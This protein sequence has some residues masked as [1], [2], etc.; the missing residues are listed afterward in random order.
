[1]ELKPDRDHLSHAVEKE[2]VN[3]TGPYK[4]HSTY[5][6]NMIHGLRAG[7]HLRTIFERWH[8]GY[9]SLGAAVKLRADWRTES[10]A[11][12]RE[13]ARL[14]GVAAY[15]VTRVLSL[16]QAHAEAQPR[17]LHRG[18]AGEDEP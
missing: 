8:A 9:G 3:A 10:T 15:T 17:R 5:Q 2:L 6:D 4:Y 7:E 16:N 1:M 12:A 14:R 11:L 18:C 13:L